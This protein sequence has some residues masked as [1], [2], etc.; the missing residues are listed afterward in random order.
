ANEEKESSDVVGR[1]I[2]KIFDAEGAGR[3]SL[4]L[5]RT[6]GMAPVRDPRRGQ[7]Y[8][9]SLHVGRT[10]HP[11]TRSVSRSVPEVVHLT[12]SPKPPVLS[13]EDLAGEDPQML[14]NV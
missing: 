7:G 5:L 1:P 12:A 14:R 13:L 11:E 4:D 2:E 9:A 6:A 3:V 8:Y 10:S